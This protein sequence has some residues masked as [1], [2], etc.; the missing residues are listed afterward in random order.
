MSAKEDSSISNSTSYDYKRTALGLILGILVNALGITTDY[1]LKLTDIQ[2]SELLLA[3]S[4]TN[5]IGFA[6][7]IVLQVSQV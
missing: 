2:F 6:F 1:F 5:T 4:V 7:S 3:Y